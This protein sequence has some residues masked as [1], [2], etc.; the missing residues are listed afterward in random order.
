M[1]S[2]RSG[3]NQFHG[4]AFEFF[5]NTILNA[6]DFF[7]KISPP[8]G[9]VPNNGRQVLNQNQYGG[10]FG[11][12]VKKDKL[13][14]FVAFQETTSG[15]GYRPQAFPILRWSGFRRVPA[16]HA[17]FSVCAGCGILPRRQRGRQLKATSVVQV[18]CNGSNINPVALN[19]LNLKNA[20]RQLLH[21]QFF[22]GSQ[23][24]HHVQ[25]SRLFTEPQAIG[26]FDYVFN[27]KNTLSGQMVL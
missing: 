3:T 23:S 27:S 12:P 2:P 26:N 19:I 17:C 16:Q 8:I 7:R 25:C 18:L 22:H 5:R 20:E 13:F 6:N 11:G 24:D 15:T 14:F 9:G 4:T 21:S 10:T 1:W